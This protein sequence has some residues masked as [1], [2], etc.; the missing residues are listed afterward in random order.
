MSN[1]I[2]NERAVGDLYKNSLKYWQN[3]SNYNFYYYLCLIY[4]GKKVK[5]LQHCLAPNN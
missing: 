5:Y 2:L 1:E 4:V 3:S